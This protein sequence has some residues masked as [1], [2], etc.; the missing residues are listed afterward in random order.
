MRHVPSSGMDS[1]LTPVSEEQFKLY[2]CS[3][4]SP[5]LGWNVIR[6]KWI[7]RQYWSDSRNVEPYDLHASEPKLDPKY[8][9]DECWLPSGDDYDIHEGPA[10]LR[11]GDQPQ[12]DEPTD[13]EEP[14]NPIQPDVTKPT[15]DQIHTDE[16][17][18]PILHRMTAT[19]VR[20]QCSFRREDPGQYTLVRKPFDTHDVKRHV[21]ITDLTIEQIHSRWTLTFNNLNRLV[22][23]RVPTTSN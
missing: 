17:A 20:H 13:T 11:Q 8:V 19:N 18:G 7:P 15:A 3:Y 22:L 16:Q 2:V 14:T 4:H 5:L 9:V 12:N 23:T 6:L 1:L 21:S 10:N